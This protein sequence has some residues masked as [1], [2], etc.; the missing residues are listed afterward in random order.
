MAIKSV[1]ECRVAGAQ[2]SRVPGVERDA[3]EPFSLS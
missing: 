1:Q 2:L 3:T